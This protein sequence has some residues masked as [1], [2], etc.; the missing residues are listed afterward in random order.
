MSLTVSNL[1]LP[2]QTNLR[3]L[4]R[5]SSRDFNK[6]ELRPLSFII[7]FDRV[8][9]FFF[10]LKSDL[11]QN[12]LYDATASILQHREFYKDVYIYMYV[13]FTFSSH[14]RLLPMYL[15]NRSLNTPIYLKVTLIYRV[16][17]Y[18]RSV[19]HTGISPPS[20]P[21]F[22]FFKGI[23]RDRG[24]FRSRRRIVFKNRRDRKRSKREEK[25][26]GKGGR[27][28]RR[29]AGNPRQIIWAFYF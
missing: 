14:R 25:E 10:F 7:G 4:I 26:E 29:V 13:W 2:P 16:D 24:C 9:C 15:P 11:P 8:F 27:E 12:N 28:A 20:L 3:I 19:L 6:L 5:E 21:L 23:G 17:T 1:R 18:T 22:L